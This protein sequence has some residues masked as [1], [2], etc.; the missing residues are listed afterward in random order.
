MPYQQY[1]KRAALWPVV[2]VLLLALLAGAAVGFAF[3]HNAEPDSEDL[4]VQPVDVPV[5]SKPESSEP[6]P[7]PAVV[8]LVGVG[9]NLIHEAI[10]KQASR[11][12]EGQGYDFGF[13]YEAVEE[14]IASAD[15]ASIN[16]ETVMD[17][18]RPLSAYPCFNS[19][20]ELGDHLEQIGFDV[21]NLANNHVLDQNASGL[22]S[23]LDYWK[24]KKIRTTGAYQDE[25][26]YQ[27]IRLLERNGVTFSFI[28]MTELTNGLSLP[29]GSELVLLRTGE[30]DRIKARIEKAKQI[31]DV[32]VV[33]VH[34]GVEYTHQPTASQRDLAQNMADWGADLIL[35]HHPHVIQPVE[36][37]DRAD[38]GRSLV[39]YSLG[40]FISA[41]SEG[42]RMIGGALDVTVVKQ[43]DGSILLENPKFLPVVTHYDPGYAN[44]RTVLLRDY[45]EE[46]AQNHGVRAQ[47]PA[48]SLEYI[49]NIVT[50]VIDPEF[51]DEVPQEPKG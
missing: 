26:D 24:T 49:H 19:P 32:V 31:S 13:T 46:L 29:A 23:T 25:A 18:N 28:G 15:I 41:Q 14:L 42:P 40:N 12:A 16:Q 10:Y 6:E 22:A 51:L 20:T 8:R 47:T 11:R 35:G 34:W 9:D 45:T 27:Q 3:W 7:E 5:L 48:F 44:V 2:L 50:T 21:A 4:P 33:N 43:P 37:L 39:V 30:E 1:R 36:W 17:R 38:G